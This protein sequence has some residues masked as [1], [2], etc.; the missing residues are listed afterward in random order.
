MNITVSKLKVS[1]W[2]KYKTLRLEA[3]KN[4][5]SAFGE[6]YEE[7]LKSNDQ[8]WKDDLQD[9]LDENGNVMFFANDEQAPIRMIGAY[10]QDTT[11]FK[12]IANICSVYVCETYRNQGIG[13]LL[14]QTIMDYLA[15]ILQFEKIKLSVVSNKIPAL[16]MYENLG[17]QQTG[18]LQKE[19]KVGN[20]Y[21][22]IYVLEK[23]NN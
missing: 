20:E 10:W 7:K 19:L 23:I 15:N 13:K 6:S 12:H 2:K 18:K 14:M 9:S 11:K 5:P 16:K 21:Y 3:L 17:F 8:Q 22:D 4:N 1:E